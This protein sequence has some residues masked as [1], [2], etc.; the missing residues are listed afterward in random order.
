MMQDISGDKGYMSGESIIG[1]G[2]FHYVYASG[3]E[4]DWMVTGFSPRKQALTLYILA[5]FNRYDDLMKKLGKFKTG[6]SCFFVK[7]LEDVDLEVQKE[8]IEESVKYM[9]EKYP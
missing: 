7:S 5:G 1:Y 4:G 3:K 2:S 6:K 8:L 9:K